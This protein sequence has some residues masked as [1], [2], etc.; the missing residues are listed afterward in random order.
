LV[1][2]G[3]REG[4]LAGLHAFAHPGRSVGKAIEIG[5]LQ[6][7]LAQAAG[8]ETQQDARVVRIGD[9]VMQLSKP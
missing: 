6:Q 5:F 9:P 1:L 2:R 4:P 8:I 3:E 7:P